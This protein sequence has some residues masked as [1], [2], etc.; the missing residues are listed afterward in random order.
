MLVYGECECFVMH[1]LD[2]CVLCASC[3]SPQCC[4]LHDWKL[5]VIMFIIR[6][7]YDVY[8]AQKYLGILLLGYCCALQ[9]M[10]IP[11]ETYF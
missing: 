7:Q 2:V 9:I 11:F 6:L 5:D 3:G 4:V 1:M 8:K 10:L